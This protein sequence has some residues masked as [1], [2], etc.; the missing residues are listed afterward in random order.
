MKE[1]QLKQREKE[2]RIRNKL[3]LWYGRTGTIA[4]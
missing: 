3:L 1:N 4:Q 2:M